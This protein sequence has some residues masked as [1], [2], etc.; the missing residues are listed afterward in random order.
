MHIYFDDVGNI[1]ESKRRCADD[2]DEGSKRAR[3][4]VDYTSQL[5]DDDFSDGSIWDEDHE[6][7]DLEEDQDDLIHANMQ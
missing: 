1:I 4:V 3:K 6:N 5:R 2:V 7:S